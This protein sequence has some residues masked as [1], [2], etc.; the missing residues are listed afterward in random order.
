MIQKCFTQELGAQPR[1]IRSKSETE[2]IIEVNNENESKAI[3][4]ITKINNV[5]VEITECS[6]INQSMGLVYIY[7]YN[8]PDSDFEKYSEDLKNEFKLFHYQNAFWIKTKNIT[9]M[10]P[11]LTFR[12]KETPKFLNI[13][14]EQS[15][16]KV[17]EYFERL[18]M[19]QV[20]LDYGH[21]AKRCKNSIPIFGK[22]N[23]RGHSIKNCRKNEI[24]Y[25]HCEDN[26]QS[27]SRKCQRYKLEI[28]VIK[29]S[30]ER[31]RVKK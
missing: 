5:D 22:C 6:N 9:A 15:K 29:N 4:T 16:T 1:T 11:I 27:F 3:L 25:H 31:T 13:I 2:F 24:I 8:V 17:F 19:C 20:Y 21:T 28:E 12:E 10:P 26:H 23:T 14:G 7:D 30:N 18:M